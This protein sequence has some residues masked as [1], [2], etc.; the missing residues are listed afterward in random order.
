M[1]FTD[2]RFILIFRDCGG[3]TPLMFAAACDHVGILGSLLQAGGNPYAP[4]DQKYTAL[5]WSCYNGEISVRN[6]L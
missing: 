4:D 1:K 2:F 6:S 3:R 5:H